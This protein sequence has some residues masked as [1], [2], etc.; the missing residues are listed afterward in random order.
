MM[1]YDDDGIPDG[2]EDV[3]H[4]GVLDSSETNPCDPDSDGDGLQDG[5]ESV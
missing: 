3:N 1:R 5:M 4:N 2:V